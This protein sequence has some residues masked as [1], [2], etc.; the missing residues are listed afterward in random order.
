MGRSVL[1][2]AMQRFR[3]HLYEGLEIYIGTLYIIVFKILSEYPISGSRDMLSIQ[4]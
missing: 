2:F 3:G 1:T 4:L